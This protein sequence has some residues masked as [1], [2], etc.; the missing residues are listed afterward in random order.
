MRALPGPPPRR[1]GPGHGAGCNGAVAGGV[2]WGVAD[3][4]L[5]RLGRDLDAA[6]ADLVGAHETAVFSVALRVCGHD[7]DAEDLT[8]E[9][10]LRAWAALRAWPAERVAAL[11][12]RPWLVT[13]CLNQWRNDLRRRSRRPRTEALGP[14]HPPASGETPEAGAERAHD[15]GRLARAL[16]GLPERQR[17]A[18]VLRH[19]AGFSYAEVAA[20]LRCPEAT[21]RSHVARGLERLRAGASEE[22]TW[23]R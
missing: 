6:F 20:V 9:T 10:F 13:I 17:V 7:V 15:A 4:L 8:A 18:V 21:A 1:G 22:G 23:R 14:A 3:G 12:L 11:E 2:Q 16:R 19:V 5:E